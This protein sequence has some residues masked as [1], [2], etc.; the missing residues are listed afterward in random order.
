MNSN[1]E[2]F[3][4]VEQILAKIKLEYIWGGFF[5]L[6]YL[7][8]VHLGGGG[9]VFWD[10]RYVYLALKFQNCYLSHA[11]VHTQMYNVY[12]GIKMVKLAED[13]C[14]GAAYAVE[15]TS[16]GSEAVSPHKIE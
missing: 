14:T 12:D 13:G 1:F 9:L 10:I 5:R 7:H 8:N 15:T 2:D 4:S 6:I 11:L 16:R 3:V